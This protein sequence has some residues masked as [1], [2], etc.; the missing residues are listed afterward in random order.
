M[1]VGDKLVTLD[2]L[3]AVYQDLNGNI[4]DLKSKS[5]VVDDVLLLKDMI[6]VPFKI[7][8]AGYIKSDGTVS[9][10]GTDYV[11]TDYVPFGSITHFLYKRGGITGSSAPYTATYDKDKN[12]IGN[13]R[14]GRNKSATG[15]EETL[16]GLTK[17]EGTEYV[18]FTLFAD[19][20]TYGE[21]AVYGDK[22]Q[23]SDLSDNVN[24]I[25][26]TTDIDCYSSAEVLPYKM[27]DNGI[28]RADTGALPGAEGYEVAKYV[29][30]SKFSHIIYSR[31][32]VTADSPTGG[33]AFYTAAS[34]DSFISGEFSVGGASNYGY[35]T[36]ITAVPSGAK[37]VSLTSKKGLDG[38]FI[39]GVQAKPLQGL[40]LSLLGAS[41]ESYTGAVPE[42]N[43]VYYDGTNAGITSVNEMWWKMLCNQT[44]MTP[45]VIDGWSGSS[46]AYNYAPSSDSSHSDAVRI[47]MCSD[48]RT[49]RLGANN[50]SPDIILI[51]GG[52][53]DY[54]YAAEGTTP[55]GDWDGHTAVDREDVLAGQSTFA[56]SYASTI[57]KLHENYPHAIV[58]G[59]SL[60]FTKRGTDLGCTRVNGVGKTAAD[61]NDTIERVCKIM[62][63]P[64][65]SIYNV[66]FNDDNYYNTY[67]VDNQDS[68]TH[69][70]A[71]GHA[72]IAKRMIEAL[73]KAVQQFKV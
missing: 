24:E 70:N 43:D 45:L 2:G 32:C 29:D 15:Y 69:P 60:L 63:C 20:T 17:W 44:G 37:Y 54:T 5:S 42:G 50:E 13:V 14:W 41:V 6:P 59:V 62:G 40:K 10:G 49:G 28:V 3:K 73:P 55:L 22:N 9:S 64:F 33:I 30:I 46:I 18:R 16:A 25:R 39:R 72:I 67:A 38:F 12:Y 21:F 56:E 19:T 4:G 57:E 71:L 35:V 7:A 31:L 61:Y 11:Y 51:V 58:V 66:G 8:G 47:P 65:I 27:A 26:Q 36:K 52:T 1:A 48:L 23:L 34:V 68:A 53:N